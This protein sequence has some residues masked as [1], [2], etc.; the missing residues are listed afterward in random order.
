MTRFWITLDQSVDFVISSL[1]LMRGGETFVPKLPSFYIIDLAKAIAP[2]LP[3]KIIG[4]R[5]GE[6]IDE[7]LCS[8][9]EAHCTYEFEDYYIVMP[10]IKFENSKYYKGSYSKSG[11][12][13]KRNFEYNSRNNKVFLSIKN[14]TKK[15]S[16]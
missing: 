8:R 16:E 4:I 7:I 6:K 15:I 9:D 10:S 11:K 12:I 3:I 1:T 2:K 14:L 13:V 5:P